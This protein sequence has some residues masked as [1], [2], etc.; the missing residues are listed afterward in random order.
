MSRITV[1][2]LNTFKEN[3][4]DKILFNLVIFGL[5]LIG[6]SILLSTLTLGEQAKIIKDI[7]LASISLF[8]TLIA[9]FVG[10]GLVSKEIERRTIY[11][12]I[13]KPLPRYMFLLGKYFGLAL[14][15]F[16]NIAIMVVGFFLILLLGHMVPDSGL[17]EAILLIFVE[18][19]VLTAVAVM[20]ST[21]TTPTL[22]A[23]FTLAIYVIG[24]LTDG[25]KA[26][27]GKL[28]QGLTKS[29]LDLLYYTLPNLSNFN[30]KGQAV[31][32]IP[33]E[34][35]YLFGAVGYGVTYGAGILVLA[36]VIFQHRDF[37]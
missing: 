10:I 28:P 34:P 19:L 4:R 1:I 2:A 37:K 5:L 16:V 21:F 32:G 27:A 18:L 24:H 3:L 23:T 25:L 20:F 26:L 13:A 33:V 9:I 31:H 14:T 15:L 11:T 8:G 6:S 36:C 29:L 22:S 35:S 12:I 30:I 7:G 17:M